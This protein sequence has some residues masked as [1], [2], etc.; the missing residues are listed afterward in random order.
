MACEITF[1]GVRKG[2]ASFIWGSSKKNKPSD[3]KSTLLCAKSNLCYDLLNP[4]IINACK[5]FMSFFWFADFVQDFILK[6]IEFTHS[7]NRE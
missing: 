7:H 4:Q 3:K 1:Q 6:F 2:V 5:S